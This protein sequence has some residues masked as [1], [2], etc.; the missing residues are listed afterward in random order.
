MK[1]FIINLEKNSKKLKASEN[2]GKTFKIF[3]KK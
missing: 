2:F 1:I 3:L